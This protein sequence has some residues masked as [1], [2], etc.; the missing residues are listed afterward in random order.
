MFNMNENTARSNERL[1]SG[2]SPDA[3]RAI[4]AASGRACKER[5]LS[6]L[7]RGPVEFDELH[8][9]VTL[10]QDTG[11]LWLEVRATLS[12]ETM[13]RLVDELQEEGLLARQGNTLTGLGPYAE[14]PLTES[15]ERVYVT[16]CTAFGKSMTAIG[17]TR[18]MKD[19][20]LNTEQIQAMLEGLVTKGY[21]EVV[22]EAETETTLYRAL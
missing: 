7:R 11:D 14:I 16:L 4:S 6:Q 5:L 15:E 13:D 19:S 17:L 9:D 2:L 1:E 10:E 21:V 8:E 18:K 3:C 20:Q 22:E 12:H